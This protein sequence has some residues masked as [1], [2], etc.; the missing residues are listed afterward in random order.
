MARTDPQLN[1]RVPQEVLDLLGRLQAIL[2]ASQAG[3]VTQA[4]RLLARRE[5]LAG[6]GPAGR[7]NPKKS[8]RST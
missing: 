1:V 5:G 6:A 2:H 8:P 4:V 7:K 3:V